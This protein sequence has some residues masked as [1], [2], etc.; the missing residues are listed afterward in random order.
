[1][2]GAPGILLSQGGDVVHTGR[3]CQRGSHPVR[4]HWCLSFLPRGLRM[5]LWLHELAR[6]TGIQGRSPLSPKSYM[7]TLDSTWS[8]KSVKGRGPF[9]DGMSQPPQVLP[10]DLGRPQDHCPLEAKWDHDQCPQKDSSLPPPLGV[11]GHSQGHRKPVTKE[12][13]PRGS[14]LSY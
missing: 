13:P 7:V 1:M 3:G 8:P 14:Y 5:A 2:L 10:P 4:P 6:Q 9:Q 11:G 12:T